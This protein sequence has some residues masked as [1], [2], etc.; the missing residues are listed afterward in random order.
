MVTIA[1]R[2]LRVLTTSSN[3][4][5]NEYLFSARTPAS[6]ACNRG[7]SGSAGQ[8]DVFLAGS[9]RSRR[10]CANVEHHQGRAGSRHGALRMPGIETNAP[11]GD[12]G[13]GGVVC[14]KQTPDFVVRYRTIIWDR[15]VE[16]DRTSFDLLVASVL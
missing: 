7:D 9:R 13:G 2:S 5:I 11:P 4:I 10:G 6:R 12:G 16:G 3:Y 14:E 8:A 1:P 15:H